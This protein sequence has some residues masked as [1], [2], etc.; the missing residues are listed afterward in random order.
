MSAYAKAGDILKDGNMSGW[1]ININTVTLLVLHNNVAGFG[2]GGDLKL[3]VFNKELEYLAEVYPDNKYKFAVSLAKDLPCPLFLAEANIYDDSEIAVY[4]ENGKFHGVATLNG[5][6]SMGSEIVPALSGVFPK[7]G[8]TKMQ[9][10]TKAPY[11]N[12]GVWEIKGKDIDLDFGAFEI[13]IGFPQGYDPPKVPGTIKSNGVVLPIGIELDG[14]YKIKANGRF[15]IL[16]NMIE[17]NGKHKWVY[18]KTE[19]QEFCIGVSFPGV[20]S[21]SG[22]LKYFKPGDAGVDAKWGTGF[23]AAVKVE[24]EKFFDRIDAV[25]CFGRAPGGYKYFFVDATAS[26]QKSIPLGAISLN[27][28]CGGVSNRMS[29]TFDPNALNFTDAFVPESLP[30]GTSASGIVYEPHATTGIGLKA[31]ADSC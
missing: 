28:F 3:P 7:V 16:G 24:F 19:I 10:S 9:I 15:A 25:G 30:I 1:P 29:S 20:K 22:C 23:Q 2:F 27:G 21:I 5:E 6:I 8:F 12:I 26:L 14:K 11:F 17:E 13:S 18:Y 4:Y 31:G